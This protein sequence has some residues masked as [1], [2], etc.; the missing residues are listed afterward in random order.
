MC[1]TGLLAFEQRNEEK[2]RIYSY[3]REH[4][5]LAPAEEK[6][7]RSNKKAW[8]FFSE[9]PPGYRRLVTYYVTSAKKDETRAGRLTKL[10][11]AC[12]KGKRLY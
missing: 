8:K 7:F 12:A 4:A 9:Q 5:S 1:P 10:I 11:D 6:R 3:E 2:S